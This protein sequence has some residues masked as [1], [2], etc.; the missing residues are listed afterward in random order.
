MAD[1]RIRALLLAWVLLVLG[2]VTLAAA[3]LLPPWLEVRELRR[4]RLLAEQ[5]ITR[6]EQRLEAV[7]RQI[8]HIQNDPAYLERIGRREFGVVPPG[9]EVIPVEPASPPGATPI[10]P[11]TLGPPWAERLETA[12]RNRPLVAVLLLPQTR[13]LV[14]ALSA[15]AVVVALVLLNRRPAVGLSRPGPPGD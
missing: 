14:L 8:D 2:G 11:P 12:A 7:A 15:G 5:R 10:E 13:P 9:V 3:V 1:S 6:L 4:Q